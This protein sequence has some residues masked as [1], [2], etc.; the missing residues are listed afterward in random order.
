MLWLLR[1]P[2]AKAKPS[3]L[4]VRLL[5]AFSST[6]GTAAAVGAPCAEAAGAAA[7]PSPAA[8]PAA[9]AAAPCA[10]AAGAAAAAAAGAPCAEPPGPSPHTQLDPPCSLSWTLPTY[11]AGPSLT[12]PNTLGPSPHTQ[13]DPPCLHA[14]TP[15][16]PRSRSRCSSSMAKM[17]SQSRASA[18]SQEGAIQST[19]AVTQASSNSERG[20]QRPPPCFILFE[21]R[22]Y[23]CFTRIVLNHVLDYLN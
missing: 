1:M 3:R 11:S 15:A 22:E 2:S 21:L 18:L 4:S 5:L 12:C 17:R 13:L 20:D 7:A 9:A 10:E 6:R 8:E 23:N 14:R 16:D 19:T